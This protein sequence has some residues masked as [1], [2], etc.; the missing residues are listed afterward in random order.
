MSSDGIDLDEE[1]R[2][3]LLDNLQEYGLEE[4]VQEMMEFI[5]NEVMKMERIQFLNAEPLERSEERTG[6]RNGFKNRTLYTKFGPLELR[7]TKD[8]ES[9]FHPRLIAT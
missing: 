2:L 8:C 6:S 4:F 5:Y 9:N 3:Q 1:V 7:V